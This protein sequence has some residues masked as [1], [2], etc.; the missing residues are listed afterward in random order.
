MTPVALITAG[1]AVTTGP[2]NPSRRSTTIAARA[3]RSAGAAPSARSRTRSSSTTARVTASTG[4]GS[5]GPPSRSRTRA[6][7]R[8][9]LGGRGRS[10][11]FDDIGSPSRRVAGARGSRTHRATPSAAPP[12]LKTGGPTGT[13]PLP[14]SMVAR[15]RQRPRARLRTYHRR[16]TTLDAPPPLRLTT[17]TDCGGCAAKLG[18]DLLA[19][20]LRGLG[21]EAALD[22]PARHSSPAW[23]R[24]TT[25]PRTGSATTSRSSARSTSSRRSSTTRGRSVRSRPRTR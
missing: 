14:W 18:A 7:T 25:P 1:G 21:A 2:A 9:T 20:A 8:S 12:V 3:S 24:P 15:G 19:D 5:R 22:A 6:R 10:A 16:V 23:T 13:P 4:A 11:G 17:L